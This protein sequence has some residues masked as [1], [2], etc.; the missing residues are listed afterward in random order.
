MYTYTFIFTNL[1]AYIYTFNAH[2]FIYM[3]LYLYVDLCTCMYLNIFIR[4]CVY[5]CVPM[6][7][8]MNIWI[9]SIFVFMYICIHTRIC[10]CVYVYIYMYVCIYV[11]ICLHVSLCI[12]VIYLNSYIIYQHSH[13]YSS[14][15]TPPHINAYI[16]IYT[17][18]HTLKWFSST[19]HS[20][21]A[22]SQSCSVSLLYF[23][24]FFFPIILFDSPCLS[25]PRFSSLPISEHADAT[26]PRDPG[27][28]DEETEWVS[29]V[30]MPVVIFLP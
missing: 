7:T 9:S 20:F 21:F 12:C 23:L 22:S 3:Y 8:Y 6:Y 29:K 13:T 5:L 26:Q 2:I 17:H 18:T 14:I 19:Y 28:S 30:V 16:Y 15:N 27:E 25:L 1:H 24:S 4:I 10:V 11:Q